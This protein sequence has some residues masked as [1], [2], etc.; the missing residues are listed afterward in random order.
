MV[1][2]PE[3]AHEGLTDEMLH[4]ACSLDVNVGE[5]LLLPRALKTRFTLG[6]QAV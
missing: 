1:R 4:K 2:H 3:D 6:R 5:C